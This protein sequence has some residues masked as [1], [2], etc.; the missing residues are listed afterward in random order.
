MVYSFQKHKALQIRKAV[1]EMIYNCKTG[2]TGGAL[3]CTDILVALYYGIMQEDAL[4][5]K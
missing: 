3:S 5:P 1:L 4:N 2:H